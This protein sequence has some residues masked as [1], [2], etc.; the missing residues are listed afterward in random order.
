MF[1]ATLSELLEALDGGALLVLP[2]A[3]AAQSL[4]SR[5]N[6]RQRRRG[7]AAWEPAKVLSW[8]QWTNTQWS[9][10]VVAGAETRL[11]LNKAQEHSLWRELIAAD[12]ETE[13]IGSADAM[14]ELAQSAWQLAAAYGATHRMRESAGT[15]DSRTFAG[16]AQSFA[17]RCVSVGYL[18][19]AQLNAAL[20]QHVKTGTLIAPESLELVGFEKVQPSQQL[21]LE[22]L[23]KRETKVRERALEYSAEGERW[24]GYAVA[25]NEREEFELAA[26]W[27]RAEVE[28]SEGGEVRVGLLVPH[29]GEVRAE[30]E[31]VLRE[32]LAPELL[33]IDADLSS[34]PWEISGGMPLS[35]V[36]MVA[37]ALA[38]ARWAEGP[39]PL[40]RVS[41]LLLSPYVG[42]RG[43]GNELLSAS[44]Q[45][46]ACKLRRTLLLRSEIDLSSVLEGAEDWARAQ[47]YEGAGSVTWL[48]SLHGFLRRVGD[49]SRPRR[50]AEWME[51]VRGIAKA[52]NWPGDRPL[53]AR[54]FAATT[55]WEGVLDL[56]ATLDFAGRSVSLRVALEE[57]ERQAQTSLF[58]PTVTGAPVQVMSVAEAEGSVFDAVAFVGATE[59]NWPTVER[60]HPLLP[61]ALQ[62]DLGMPGSDSARAYAVSREFTRALLQRSWKVLFTHAAEGESESLRP[63]SLLTELEMSRVDVT[64]LVAPRPPVEPIALECIAESEPLP[65]LPSV[66]VRGGATVLKLQAA[67]GFLAFAQLRLRAAEPKSSD[68]G[69][70][71]GESGNVVHRALQH[72][73][74]T[75]ETQ[76][77]L[78]LLSKTER[79]GILA[80]SIDAAMPRKLQAR[81]EW[82]L[83]YVAV[84]KERLRSLLQRWLDVELQRG[85][86]NVLAVEREEKVTVGPLSLDVRMDRIDQVGEGVFFVDYKTGYAADPKQWGGERPDEPQLPLYTFL[87]EAGELKGVAFAKVRAG[88][89]MKWVGYQAEEGILPA[90]RSKANVRD[91]AS[92]VE[93][94][95][96]TLTLLA[97]DF[98]TGR[99]DVRPKS[100]EVNCARCGQ[101]LL[102]RVDPASLETTSEEEEGQDMDG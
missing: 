86:F 45:F 24:R 48:R 101:R 91:M 73:W 44:A 2:N 28:R 40:A 84:Q 11:L 80:A 85:P 23:R 10:L 58:S 74:K 53:T 47:D 52:A 25:A 90:S 7:L 64:Q 87:P 42:H 98:A 56:V 5:F 32:T 78:R 8:S 18:S 27:I 96:A 38:L 72:F 31:D 94:W 61:W 65:A 51:L 100:F 97:E 41:S 63:S 49:M 26:R 66:E 57:L 79:E 43:E 88:Q 69:L 12:G 21:L 93:E 33:S 9:E 76:E 99:A 15:H 59:E 95:H 82:D 37:D 13:L 60:A 17:K 6:D 3:R 19:Q 29:L 83:A 62:H 67:C 20:Q 1:S 39:L 92:L 4:R 35:R 46:D 54:D 75:V 89:E 70:D 30:I 22:A 34:T 55:A 14:A 102:C 81:D 71:A 16:W 77:A 36:A 68:M 50:F